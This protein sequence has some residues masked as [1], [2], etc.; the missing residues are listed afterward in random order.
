MIS[1]GAV[2]CESPKDLP[3]E[4]KISAGFDWVQGGALRPAVCYLQSSLKYVN[5]GLGL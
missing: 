1:G 5:S 2:K 3:Q 4:G